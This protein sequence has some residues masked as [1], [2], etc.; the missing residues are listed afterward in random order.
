MIRTKTSV[1][2]C[3]ILLIDVT[4]NVGELGL[5]QIRKACCDLIDGTL[6]YSSYGTVY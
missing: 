1:G 6:L 3:T 2:I 5:A 4:S